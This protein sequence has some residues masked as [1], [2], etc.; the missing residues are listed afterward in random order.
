MIE[1]VHL[2][3]GEVV[4]RQVQPPPRQK[5]LLDALKQR[6]PETAPKAEV[7]VGTRKE[8][9]QVRKPLKIKGGIVFSASASKS[10]GSSVT[11]KALFVNSHSENRKQSGPPAFRISFHW[12]WYGEARQVRRFA[13]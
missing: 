1:L 12:L 3:S 13:E 6:L 7:T 5:Q 2:Q 8:I 4:A 10:N 9:N 11:T